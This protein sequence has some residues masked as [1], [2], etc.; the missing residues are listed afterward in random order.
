MSD[1]ICLQKQQKK[2]RQKHLGYAFKNKVRASTV[3]DIF[4]GSGKN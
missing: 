3:V 1:N 2:G 4:L